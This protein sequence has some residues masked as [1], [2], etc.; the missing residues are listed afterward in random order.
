M[1]SKLPSHSRPLPP[2]IMELVWM[3]SWVPLR[4]GLWIH[5]YISFPLCYTQVNKFV[6]N[7]EGR[8][9]HCETC[10]HIALFTWQNTLEIFTD[11]HIDLQL[12]LNGC[13]VFHYLD[14]LPFI[15][16]V[17]LRGCLVFFGF[18]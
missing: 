5:K 1:G 12:S 2:S 18:G 17:P 15:N 16:Y 3:V 4:T 9:A 14:M 7:R 13:I 6:C 10:L 8:S 11:Q